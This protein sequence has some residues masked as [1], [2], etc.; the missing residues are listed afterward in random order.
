MAENRW[1]HCAVRAHGCGRSRDLLRLSKAFICSA[2]RQI[3]GR[4]AVITRP[5][6]RFCLYTMGLY[7]LGVD[8]DDLFAA[9]ETGLA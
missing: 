4:S 3:T 7:E 2:F 8:P 1:A 6:R 5:I 9:D